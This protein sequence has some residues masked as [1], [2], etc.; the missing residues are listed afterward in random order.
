MSTQTDE[1]KVVFTADTSKLSDAQSKLAKGFDTFTKSN[2]AAIGATEALTQKFSGLEA[3]G[4]RLGGALSGI[5]KFARAD[6]LGKIGVGAGIIGAIGVAALEK[7]GAEAEDA[8]QKLAAFDEQFRKV[9]RSA[10]FARS[11]E[12]SGNLLSRI[13]ANRDQQKELR[14]LISDNNPTTALGKAGQMAGDYMQYGFQAGDMREMINK[15]QEQQMRL[16]GQQAGK[17]QKELNKAL[18]DERKLTQDIA[19]G[20]T[21]AAAIMTAEIAKAR[22]L[23][24]LD[25][26]GLLTAKRKAEV[27]EKYAALTN[28]I[29]QD[30]LFVTA[31]GVGETSA[32]SLMSEGKSDQAAQ[33]RLDYKQEAERRALVLSGGQDQLPDLE[34]RQRIE[35]QMLTNQQT[36]A[37][38]A[39]NAAVAI[40]KIEGSNLSMQLKQVQ[41]ADALLR[42]TR[43]ELKER[44]GRTEEQQR[45]LQLQERSAA[46]ALKQARQDRDFELR[47][48]PGERNKRDAQDIRDRT[49]RDKFDKKQGASGGLTNLHRDMSGNPI[50][51]IDPATGKRVAMD[52]GDPSSVMSASDK[53]RASWGWNPRGTLDGGD[54]SSDIRKKWNWPE[55]GGMN[56]AIRSGWG[57]KWSDS[58]GAAAMAEPDI[59]KQMGWETKAPHEGRSAAAEL[60]EIRTEGLKIR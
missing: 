49:E 53:I 55:E 12:G 60:R 22:E 21:D 27:T 51:G 36:A 35:G 14:G 58:P 56:A 11:S 2:R 13:G 46:A 34:K 8:T 5:A 38:R 44:R 48:K 40:S 57:G 3:A 37:Q 24:A 1:V 6:V 16:A 17:M 28:R 50:S 25:E 26:A 18:E 45:A 23:T 54:S 41:A 47:N 4:V 43:E 29:Q 20:R 7:F 10:T 15:G 59:Q 32:V 30:R 31:Q 19:E 9:T 33:R 52:G 42:Y 39:F